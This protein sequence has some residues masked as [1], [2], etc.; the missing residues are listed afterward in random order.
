MAFKAFLLLLTCAM[1]GFTQ[2]Q[3][4]EGDQKPPFDQFRSRLPVF[5][6]HSDTGLSSF[7][8]IVVRGLNDP[9]KTPFAAVDGFKEVSTGKMMVH[10][11]DWIY[12]DADVD[13]YGNETIFR[14]GDPSEMYLSN[15]R[16]SL[17]PQ[18]SGNPISALYDDGDLNV[19]NSGFA[20]YTTVY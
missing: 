2:V 13:D 4:T 18:G 17:Y 3:G 10:R 1:L 19:K 20:V 12:F 5:R 6:K 16:Y 15:Y 8:C 9:N 7:G 14:E 11:G